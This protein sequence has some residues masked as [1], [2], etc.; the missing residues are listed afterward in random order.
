MVALQACLQQLVDHVRLQLGHLTGTVRN[1]KCPTI[2]F[3]VL[4]VGRR[5]DMP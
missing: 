3:D 5:T 2:P 1:H 4:R